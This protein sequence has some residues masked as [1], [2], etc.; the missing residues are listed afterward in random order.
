MSFVK[1]VGQ[2]LLATMF[3]QGGAK[4]FIEPGGR[5]KLV[6]SAGIPQPQQAV[7]LN[8]AL[9]VIGG[10]A[11]ALDITPK[12]AALALLGSLVPTTFVG[13]P[14]WKEETPAT[15][16]N[17]QIHFLKNISMIGGLLVVLGA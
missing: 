2:V 6:E 11:L 14:F 12:L 17:H 9:M 1:S 5:V 3:I 7:V 10:T 13:H 16:A 15:R 8:G 4:A